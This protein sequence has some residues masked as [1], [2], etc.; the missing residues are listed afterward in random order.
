MK[1]VEYIENYYNNL[2]KIDQQGML[3]YC[4]NITLTNGQKINE[5]E[6]IIQFF[7]DGITVEYEYSDHAGTKFEVYSIDKIK[8]IDIKRIN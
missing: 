7:E 6:K 2:P 4:I 8:E 3:Q 1:T 5:K